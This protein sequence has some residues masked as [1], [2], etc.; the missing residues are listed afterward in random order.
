VRNHKIFFSL[1]IVITWF[2]C[3]ESNAQVSGR[4]TDANQHPLSQVNIKIKETDRGTQTNFQGE[5][6]IIVNPG[7]TLIFSHLG[8][9]PE[10][11]RVKRRTSVINIGMIA[12]SIEIEGVEI[13]SRVKVTTRYKSQ[14]ELLKEYPV[15]KNL[16]KT[17]KGILNRD[18]SS[19]AFRIVDGED[20]FSGGIDFFAALQA[21][22]PSM[23]VIR[24]SGGVAIYLR[25]YGLNAYT[26]LFE[27]DGFFGPPPTY[28]S[29]NDIDR[30]AV[31]EGSAA[32]M[33]YGPDGA[34]G[35]IVVNTKAQTWMDDIGV[36]RSEGH[37]HFLDS[38]KTVSHLEPYSPYV[39]PYLEKLHKVRRE[40]K[41]LAIVEDQQKSHLS[42]PYYFL[43]MYELF[44]SRW[45]NNEN[46]K[47]L[48]QN[49][50]DNFS[51]DIPV[52]K[53][54]AYLQQQYGNY[55]SALL[56]YLEIL[57]SQSWYAQPLR[58]V[59]NAYAEVGDYEKAWMYYTQ[60]IDI[61]EQLPNA[62]FDA[63][64]EDLLITTEMENLL[65]RNKLVFFDP[66]EK[67]TGMEDS[68]PQTRLVFE[69]NNQE[70]DF[71]LQFVTPEGYYDTWSNKTGK[72]V[73]QNP[74]AGNGYSSHQFFLGKENIG[75]W[76]VNIDY[77]GNCSELPTYLM[78]TVY[79]DYGLPSQQKEIKTYKLSK[80]HDKVQ[81]L[82]LQQY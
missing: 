3:Q 19:T 11:I 28:L 67:V 56:L 55:E 5:Y 36:D 62:T 17:S 76:Q 43:E 37:R 74:I 75:L 13:K 38:L 8:M 41:A 46:S 27:V 49:I 39:P 57:K 10:E 15:N 52:L 54:L 65:E 72:D 58:D 81:L 82:T 71:E 18:L 64:G 34:G 4:V 2:S 66:Y 29:A 77:K 24:D 63:Y 70:A 20:L 40:T 78:V 48:S 73:S 22:I 50:A 23:R 42:N 26:A 16:I 68:D 51:D 7:D 60:Y 47:E 79:R 44:L 69:W 35:V 53:A 6:S 59:A 33:R 9:Q 31:L 14:K 61:I 32:F 80:D 21:H 1:I 25:Q 12:V 45:G 30:I